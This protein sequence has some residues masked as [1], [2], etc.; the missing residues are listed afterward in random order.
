MSDLS[1]NVVFDNA[2]KAYELETRRLEAVSQAQERAMQTASIAEKV[3]EQHLG[4]VR[5]GFTIQEY[6]RSVLAFRQSIAERHRAA[7]RYKRF[8]QQLAMYNDG[9][10]LD[11]VSRQN[12]WAAF[13]VINRL[14][15][16]SVMS[17]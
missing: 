17:T 12:V 11:G 10:R 8:G 5:L 6:C 3:V 2:S 4:N 14:S 9:H 15:P 7:E 13:T 16:A 1:A